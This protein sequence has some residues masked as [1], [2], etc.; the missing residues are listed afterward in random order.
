MEV[1]GELEACIDIE[2]TLLTTG[3]SVSLPFSFSS[4]LPSLSLCF[5]LSAST[6]ISTFISRSTSISLRLSSV[7]S[8]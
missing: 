5:Y 4:P 6:F 3:F 2:R 8:R 1:K 7:L